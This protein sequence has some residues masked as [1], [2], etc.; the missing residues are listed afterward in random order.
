MKHF[1]DD[2]RTVADMSEIERRPLIIPR[3]PGSRKKE[4][5][6]IKDRAAMDGRPTEDDESVQMNKKAR[7]SFIG[8][9]LAA[10]LAVAAVFAIAGALLILALTKVW[11]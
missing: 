4:S 2:G 11:A 3:L 7:A 6:Q 9:A 1:D 8:G 10:A 5:A